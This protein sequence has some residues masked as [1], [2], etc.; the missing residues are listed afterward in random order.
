MRGIQPQPCRWRLR[1]FT[2]LRSLMASSSSVEGRRMWSRR[3]LAPAKRNSWQRQSRNIQVSISLSTTPFLI[4]CYT[5]TFERYFTSP[6]QLRFLCRLIRMRHGKPDGH[7]ADLDPRSKSAPSSADLAPPL[8][9]VSANKL[10][11][12]IHERCS[13]LLVWVDALRT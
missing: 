8:K 11:L 2:S 9:I 6:E 12:R 13:A 3:A 5:P 4:R 10:L 7:A 1:N